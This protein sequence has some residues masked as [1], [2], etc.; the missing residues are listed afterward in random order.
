MKLFIK[1]N[2]DYCYDSNQIQLVRPDTQ[3]YHYALDQMGFKPEE[4]KTIPRPPAATE[5]NVIHGQV[6]TKIPYLAELGYRAI[7]LDL[8]GFGQSSCPPGSDP[9]MLVNRTH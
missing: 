1:L 3:I 4:L 6:V 7:A 9:Q 5:S 2:F 8:R